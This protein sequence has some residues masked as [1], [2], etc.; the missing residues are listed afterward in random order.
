MTKSKRSY[1]KK[2][3]LF[4][5]LDCLSV[6]KSLSTN[7]ISFNEYIKTFENT[8]LEMEKELLKSNSLTAV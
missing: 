2:Q 5:V 4:L 3:L 1:F 7:T 8:L 6:P